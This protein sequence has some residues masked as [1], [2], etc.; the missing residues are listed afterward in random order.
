MISNPCVGQ[1][2]SSVNTDLEV[3]NGINWVPLYRD[4]KYCVM[5]KFS[6]WAHT[7]DLTQHPFFFNNLEM[8]EWLSKQTEH[9]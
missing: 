6:D 1:I 5:C 9:V 8:L 2:R 3:Y 4:I 7:V